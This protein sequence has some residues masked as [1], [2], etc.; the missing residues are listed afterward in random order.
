MLT[1]T[2][3]NVG[4]SGGSWTRASADWKFHSYKPRGQL[5]LILNDN[6]KIVVREIYD[7]IYF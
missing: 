2:E 7:E 5:R 1:C 6:I 3:L 4:M